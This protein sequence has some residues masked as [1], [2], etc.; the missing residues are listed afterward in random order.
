MM[1]IRSLA[2]FN[3]VPWAVWWLVGTA[4]ITAQGLTLP[5]RHDPARGGDSYPATSGDPYLATS[6][7]LF[8]ATDRERVEPLDRADDLSS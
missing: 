4:T 2:V 6:E 5:N 1:S 3:E 8:M 7:D